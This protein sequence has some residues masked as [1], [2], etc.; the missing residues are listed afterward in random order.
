MTTDII[1]R[2]DAFLGESDSID[3]RPSY[4]YHVTPIKRIPSIIRE[5]LDPDAKVGPFGKGFGNKVEQRIFMATSKDLA[6][7]WFKLMVS[8]YPVV[9]RV[10]SGAL[11]LDSV[12]PDERANK[13]FDTSSQS[14]NVYTD[15]PVPPNAIELF[16]GEGW[17]PLRNWK[18]KTVEELK[19]SPMSDISRYGTRLEF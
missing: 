8:R 15:E 13:E 4:F 18:G 1:E 19:Q 11:D 17:E 16:N 5:G 14:Q 2:I 3:V 12:Y 9:L 10:P 6:R 7:E